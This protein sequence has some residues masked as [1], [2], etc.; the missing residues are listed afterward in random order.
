M[1]LRATALLIGLLLPVLASADS[2]GALT[3]EAQTFRALLQRQE[4]DIKE[5]A[6]NAVLEAGADFFLETATGATR[7]RPAD[8]SL[9]GVVV[10]YIGNIPYALKD[11]PLQAWFA[12]YVGDMVDRGIVTGY[13]D[14]RGTPTGLFGPERNV[15]MEELAQMSVVAAGIGAG[16]G[17]PRNV[18]AKGTWSAGAVACAEQHGF[19]LYGDGTVD[20]KRPATRAEVVMTVLQ[21]FGAPLR[22][23]TAAGPF[24]DVTP[25]T[26]FSSAISTAV[27]DGIVSGYTDTT[28]KLTGLFGPDKPVNRAEVSKMLSLALQKYAK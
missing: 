17:E 26:L 22:D 8:P 18:A 10:L 15:S 2:Y 23:M 25:S 6:A 13:K 14:A 21:A 1:R 20:I 24:T 7:E 19:A 28:G 12:P 27:Q 5:D 9:A 4:K 16:C 3:E 11:V